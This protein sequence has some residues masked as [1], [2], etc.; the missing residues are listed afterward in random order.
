MAVELTTGLEGKVTKEAVKRVVGLVLER[1]EGSGG[2]EMKKKAV[3]AGK[4]LRDALREEEVGLGFKGSSI[5]AM[6]EFLD[7]IVSGGDRPAA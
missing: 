5:K 3:E 6:D 4:K 2:E 7:A 1:E